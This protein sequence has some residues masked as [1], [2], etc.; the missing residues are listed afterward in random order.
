MNHI[1]VRSRIG[2]IFLV[3]ILVSIPVPV[4][5]TTG[6]DQYLDITATITAPD[7]A[8]ANTNFTVAV[9]GAGVR[10]YSVSVFAYGFYENAI[11]AY[12]GN[13]KVS[14]TSGTL[15]E[16]SGFN[17]GSGYTKNH[18]LNKPAGTY[19]YTFIFGQRSFG[20]GWYDVAVDAYVTIKAPKP[21][22]CDGGWRPPLSDVGNAGKVIPLK[23]T[24]Y[25]CENDTKEFYRDENVIV[26]VENGAGTVVNSF[27]YTGNP[28]TGVD[29]DQV[30]KQYH[31][32]WDT[33]K[34]MVGTYTIK[35]LFDS[36]VFL[37]RNITLQ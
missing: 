12:D 8:E 25:L 9:T 35:V 6:Y 5:A 31:V 22:I 10:D 34:V 26:R 19:K 7:T 23:F 28:H 32:N 2:A 24:A 14:V 17:W 33:T 16:G 18:I 27:T 11:W 30:G 36:T 4:S 21:K 15:L 29:I 37:S 3:L 20:H 1:A 13:H